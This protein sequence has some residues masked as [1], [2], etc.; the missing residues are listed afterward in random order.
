VRSDYELTPSLFRNYPAPNEQGQK[1]FIKEQEQDL[2][3]EFAAR[4]RQ[5]HGVIDDDWDVLFAMQHYGVPTRLLDWTENLAVAVSFA[6]HDFSGGPGER[7]EPDPKKPPCVWVLNPYELNAESRSLDLY[8]P[9]NLGWDEDDG[10]YWTYSE[11][12]LDD[13]IDWKLP[14]AVY[15]RQRTDRMQAQRGWFTIHGTD[16]GPMKANESYLRRVDIPADCVNAAHDYLDGAGIGL[17]N[18]LPELPSL[19]LHLSRQREHE[20]LEFLT[21]PDRGDHP[22]HSRSRKI[23]KRRRKKA[24]GRSK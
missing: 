6:I 20:R 1:A 14:I 17:F 2:Y 18:L 22:A 4:A 24:H 12:L 7:H 15:P 8:D 11:M 9:K 10:E 23:S 13:C 3:Y 5:L 16:F 21:P 19:A